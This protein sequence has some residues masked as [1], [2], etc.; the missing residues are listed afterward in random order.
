[1]S[2][3]GLDKSINKSRKLSESAILDLDKVESKDTNLLIELA[4]YISY[5]EK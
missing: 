5:R 4:E 2:V 1:M 3:I